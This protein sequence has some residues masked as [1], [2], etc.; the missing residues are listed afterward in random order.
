LT[1]KQLKSDRPSPRSRLIAG[2]LVSLVAVVGVA[3]APAVGRA[4]RTIAPPGNS[5]VNQYVE[6]IPT[7]KGN[8]PTSTI[9]PGGPGGGSTGRGASSGAGGRL[10]S[11]AAR[12][13]AKHGATGRSAAALASATGAGA[14]PP[15]HVSGATGGGSSP[16]ATLVKD[17]TG[18]GSGSGLGA[19]LPV[20][21]IVIAI[22]GAAL[23][24]KRRR[25]A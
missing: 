21:L 16:L 17:T 2:L 5:A 13:F 4:K 24:L 20:L 22:T 12:A 8:R 3:A 25:T 14:S 10:S 18:S 1:L 23:A 9:T 6:D 19:I 7:A 11:T 15:R